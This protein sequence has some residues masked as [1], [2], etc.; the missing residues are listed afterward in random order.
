MDKSI[1]PQELRRIFQG[2]FRSVILFFLRL[3]PEY[4]FLLFHLQLKI[5]L[6]SLIHTTLH[7]PS[8]QTYGPPNLNITSNATPTVQK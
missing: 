7:S 1:F 2:H 8:H 3:V 5:I 6:I 4:L